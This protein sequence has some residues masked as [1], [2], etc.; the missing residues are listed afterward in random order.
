MEA[1]L[2][3]LQGELGPVAVAA[4]VL[5][6]LLA[7][8]RFE[9]R[10]RDSRWA[11]GRELRRAGLLTGRGVIL[12][13]W[14]GRPLRA[15]GD[16][17]VL[18][19]APTRSG[20]GAGFVIPNLLDWPGSVVVLDVKGENYAATAGWRKENGQEVYRF[21]PGEAG[22]HCWNPL[23][24][25]ASDPVARQRD[26]LR[27]AATLFP[28][29]EGRDE[30]WASM[31][32]DLFAGAAIAAIDARGGKANLGDVYRL[33][34]HPNL[35]EFVKDEIA[36]EG[37]RTASG[38][39]R[40]LAWA[41]TDAPA[42]RAGVLASAR[43]KM[44][45]WGDPLLAA[46]TSVSDFDLAAL[47]R[48]P[49]SLYVAVSPSDLGRLSQVLRMLFEQLVEVNTHEGFG[50]DT[51]CQVPLLLMLDE[52]AAFGRVPGFERGISFVAAYGIRICIVAQS[53]AQLR[54]V[55]GEQGAQTLIDNCGCRLM[56]APGSAGEAETMSR[57]LGTR[58]A[59]QQSRTGRA[60]LF[61]GKGSVTVTPVEQPLLRPEEMRAL[62]RDGAIAVLA[63]C[64]PARLRK[65]RWYRDWRF[66]SRLREPPGSSN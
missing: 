54:L 19:A 46:A 4:A 8:P 15:A 44:L 18:L 10:A 34:H 1:A 56:F 60:G 53:E 14:K 59:R 38:G 32:R 57:L 43:E 51:P 23:A 20:K 48:R 55:Y 40:L 61:A 41:T 6:L 24:T 7:L 5:A 12:G 17:H 49:M 39:N 62:G 22:S 11:T 37:V 66:K 64:R 45:V 13:L 42:T 21:A 25:A 30:F 26:V 27:L 16:G 28:A 63:D 9:G 3:L 58:M 35:A 47:R 2:Q 31:A 33:L 52:F 65:I 36:E 50:P 29:A